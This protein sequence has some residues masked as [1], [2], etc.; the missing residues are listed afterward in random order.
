MIRV[1]RHTSDPATRPSARCVLPA[2]VTIAPLNCCDQADN[3]QNP[4]SGHFECNGDIST[5]AG[6]FSGI[7]SGTSEKRVAKGFPGRPMCALSV[8]LLRPFSR[9]MLTRRRFKRP[10]SSYTLTA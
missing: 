7:F 3:T 5:T 1:T 9:P 6:I 2:T 8:I 10:R 4:C